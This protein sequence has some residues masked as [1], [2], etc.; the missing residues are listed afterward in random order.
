M[1]REHVHTFV[2]RTYICHTYTAFLSESINVIIFL[3]ECRYTVCIHLIINTS[4]CLRAC[5]HTLPLCLSP[6]FSSLF[7]FLFFCNFLFHSLIIFFSF[8]SISLFFSFFPIYLQNL[9][10]SQPCYFP[11]FSSIFSSFHFFIFSFSH[12][13][14]FYFFIFYY[15]FFILYFYQDRRV[16][17]IEILFITFF[18]KST[19]KRK[20]SS[21][22]H[23]MRY[24]RS[25]QNIVF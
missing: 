9:Y 22:H 14:I 16:L 13:F 6:P 5:V 7:L 1:V 2:T 15:L 8:L 10:H 23:L 3:S 11:S 21:L 20:F 24:V 25:A 17:V 4:L 19:E 18:V 12:H